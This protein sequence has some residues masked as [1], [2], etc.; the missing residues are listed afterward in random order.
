MSSPYLPSPALP[1]GLTARAPGPEDV[2]GLAALATAAKQAVA[3]SGSVGEDEVAMEVAGP[4][5]WTRRQLV[6]LAEHGPA[7]LAWVRV[8]DRAA[9]RTNVDLTVAPDLPGGDAVAEA[10][11][12]WAAE[13]GVEVAGLRGLGGTQLHVS[14]HAD[15]AD[16]QRRLAAAGFEQTR[17]WLQMSR[18][19]TSADADLPGPREGVVVR[20]VAT[21][22]DGMPVAKDLQ[23]V[24]RML[25]E[26]FADHFNSYRESFPEF[27]TRQREVTGH[28]WDHWWIAEITVDDAPAGSDG[29]VPGGAVVSSVLPPDA[30]G[31]AGSYID[32]IGVHRLS[33]GR[34]VAKALLRTVIRDALDRGRNRVALEVDADSPTGADGLYTSMGWVTRY[35]TQSWHKPVEVYGVDAPVPEARPIEG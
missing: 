18:P 1:P 13:A 28:R 2:R 32:Y 19:V 5:S 22:E 30:D 3:G 7:P 21:H 26:S 20:R 27:L 16:L 23:T 29:W 35:E 10:L 8:H 4:G 6:V 31:L 25:E 14:V 34:G 24:H 11:L 33:R 9:G 12:A 17:T 15:D